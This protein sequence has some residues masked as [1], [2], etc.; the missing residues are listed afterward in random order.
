M[1]KFVVGVIVI[2]SV[3]SAELYEITPQK[4]LQSNWCW[5]ACM[6]M[7]LAYIGIEVEQCELLESGRE[8]YSVW[9]I[10]TNDCIAE[11][12][13]CNFFNTMT[14]F[15]NSVQGLYKTDYQ[16]STK[17]YTRSLSK[18]EIE[19]ALSKGYL[20]HM[21]WTWKSGGGH[22][23][24]LVG[25]EGNSVYY[26]DPWEGEQFI[27][28]LSEVKESDNH[29][30]LRSLVVQEKGTVPMADV[31]SQ[32]KYQRSLKVQNKVLKLDESFIGKSLVIRNMHGKIIS[33]MDINTI[34]IPLLQVGTGAYLFSVYGEKNQ[35]LITEP[36]AIW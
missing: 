17:A 5:A 16:I 27:M 36:H 28:P 32:V 6:Q 4:Q 7:A 11:P 19:D 9:S 31:V 23:L 18:K 12:E 15:S 2:L 14:G 3:L 26:V 34:N 13:K 29:N 20:I 10:N 1:K 33:H 35:L 21:G 24:L 8:K 25:L 30:W 22:Q